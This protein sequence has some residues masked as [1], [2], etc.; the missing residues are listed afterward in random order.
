[1]ESLSVPINFDRGARPE[2]AVVAPH[3]P[4][5]RGGPCFAPGLRSPPR[6]AGTVPASAW[7]DAPSS[8]SGHPL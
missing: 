4:P 1:L 3:G 5:Q 8:T 2:I 6:S 7:Q